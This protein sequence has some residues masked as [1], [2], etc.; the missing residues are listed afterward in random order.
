MVHPFHVSL[1][2]LYLYIGS[3][4]IA[5]NAVVVKMP[6]IFA[7]NVESKPIWAFV[8]RSEEYLSTSIIM[9]PPFDY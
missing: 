9:K 5:S 7:N 8:K 4:L 3:E 2:Q 1:F 6:Q